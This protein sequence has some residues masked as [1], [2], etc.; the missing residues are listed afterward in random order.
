MS[1]TMRLKDLDVKSTLKHLEQKWNQVV[2]QAEMKLVELDNLRVE[3][4]EKNT[5]LDSMGRWVAQAE[6]QLESE[7]SL[8][9]RDENSLREALAYYEVR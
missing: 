6:D 1:A 5:M 8:S 2:T 4:T 3:W 9:S 7:M